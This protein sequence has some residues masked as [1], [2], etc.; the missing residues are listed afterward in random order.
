MSQK[1]L[2][3]LTVISFSLALTGCGPEQKDPQPVDVD[4]T[5]VK[6]V[7]PVE[8]VSA[9]IALKFNAGES[10]IYKQ[11]TKTI[12]DYKFEQP[13][14]GEKGEVK[15][16]QNLTKIET[17]FLQEIQS[18]NADSSAIA[19]ITLKGILV[20]IKDRNGVKI[21]YDSGR[22]KDKDDPLNALVG[23][24]YTISISSDGKVKVIDAK[25]ARSKPIEGLA[26]R[27]SKNILSD[28]EIIAR[29]EIC[30]PGKEA[31]TVETGKG[32]TK[33]VQSHPKLLEQ[34]AFEKSY[35]FEGVDGNIANVTMTAL[36]TDK[37]VKGA[38]PQGGGFGIMAKMFDSQEKYKGNIKFDINAG[39][40]I[41][42]KEEFVAT[43]IASDTTG[44]S[45]DKGPDTLTMGLTHIITIGQVD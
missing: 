11:T 29:H 32:W 6:T 38:S 30:L 36:E 27:V 40:V 24:S 43:Y 15:I 5:S 39:Q 8:T 9:G 12:Q 19:K 18:V 35:V 16:E 34:K 31:S 37:A 44:K 10:A 17:T 14:V 41:D 28:K 1:L 22:E 7:D 21:D 4:V 26:G 45:G 23:K 25:G 13:N 20:Y 2:V 3:A 33:V 42:L